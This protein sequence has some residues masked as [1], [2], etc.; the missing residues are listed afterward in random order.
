MFGQPHVQIDASE[1]LQ[2]LSP[3]FRVP[4]AD[5]TDEL[6]APYRTAH[7]NTPIRVH[8]FCSSLF[9][10]AG[11]SARSPGAA[12]PAFPAILLCPGPGRPSIRGRQQA[13]EPALIR[14][15]KIVSCC[16][17]IPSPIH[18]HAPPCPTQLPGAPLRTL[19]EQHA[20]LSA[21]PAAAA[22]AAGQGGGG[23]EEAPQSLPCSIVP[24][25]WQWL[26]LPSSDRKAVLP[27]FSVEV[28]IAGGQGPAVLS[29][30]LRVPP[31]APGTAGARAGTRAAGGAG[32]AGGAVHSPLGG[33]GSGL[34][35][36][37]VHIP[38]DLARASMRPD[39]YRVRHSA[40]SFRVAV[41]RLAQ[42]AERA[43]GSGVEREADIRGAG[44][45]AETGS[46][47][48]R[49]RAAG[50]AES[51][52]VDREEDANE[53]RAHRQAAA[54]AGASG[55]GLGARGAAEVAE[56]APGAAAAAVVYE[57]TC[58]EEELTTL[59]VQL[60][61]EEEG[62][63]LGPGA[64][65]EFRATCAT[66][67]GWEGEGRTLKAAGSGGSG[68][69]VVAFAPPRLAHMPPEA[70]QTAAVAAAAAASTRGM[71]EV[72]AVHRMVLEPASPS[73]AHVL[74]LELIILVT[75]RG[76]TSRILMAARQCNILPY[77]PHIIIL[78]WVTCFLYQ[79]LLR[80]ASF[81]C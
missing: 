33:G 11:A 7:R 10:T 79:R 2:P 8:H 64:G 57:V 67:P 27:L 20:C 50:P 66:L 21:A 14:G 31:M 60:E 24:G 15:A 45:R 58:R 36:G 26:S 69:L 81:L 22:P 12:Q 70:A 54:A 4:A 40:D 75:V 43:A 59:E 61:S 56:A 76:S 28:V 35:L 51:G 77:T 37:V 9:S 38:V 74:P 39:G 73:V 5:I 53:G 30:E 62:V 42:D 80:A 44:C 48:K 46:G 41:V 65:G 34:D 16:R 49:P 18:M 23:A 71:R 1:C 19:L 72:R 52:A 13:W 47:R 3:P 68:A 63:L 32:G 78:L 55:S 6:S 17:T 25:S 29:L